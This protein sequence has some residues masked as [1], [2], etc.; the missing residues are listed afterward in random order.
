M[1]FKQYTYRTLLIKPFGPKYHSR[2][3]PGNP[4]GSKIPPIIPKGNTQPALPKIFPT[5][6]NPKS[7]SEKPS[8][9]SKNNPFIG[10]QRQNLMDQ[11]EAAKKSLKMAA[12]HMEHHP[13]SQE[14]AGGLLHRYPASGTSLNIQPKL[15]QQHTRGYAT[16][17]GNERD[18]KDFSPEAIANNPLLNK[19]KKTITHR[20][21]HRCRCMLPDCDSKICKQVCDVLKDRKAVGHASHGKP[22]EG[23]TTVTVSQTD[24]Q[25]K[26]KPQNVVFYD[27]AHDTIQTPE[28]PVMTQKINTDPHIQAAI[29]TH[30]DTK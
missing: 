6:S 8:L 28:D 22:P 13:Q 12:S 2:N 25:G 26:P 30:E 18:K 17:S 15:N 20:E 10:N 24:F 29:K 19:G 7:C 3:F 14:H 4:R 23:K 16:Y 21:V 27:K 9:E 1:L 5:Y 11:N